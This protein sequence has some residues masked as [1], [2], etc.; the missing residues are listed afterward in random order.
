M[1]TVEF[2]KRVVS[3]CR[4][5]WET[6]RS[7]ALKSCTGTIYAGHVSDALTNLTKVY[8]TRFLQSFQLLLLSVHSFGCDRNISTTA[9]WIAIHDPQR[10]TCRNRRQ[11]KEWTVYAYFCLWSWRWTHSVTSLKWPVWRTT[12]FGTSVLASLRRH[13]GCSL[14]STTKTPAH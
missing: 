1:H 8:D 5:N 9:A 4:S 10:M 14:V 12:A 6:D 11:Y 7:I 2:Q 13:G 3:A